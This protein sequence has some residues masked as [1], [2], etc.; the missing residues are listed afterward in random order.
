MKEIATEPP[1]GTKYE[2]YFA[3]LGK[4]QSDGWRCDLSYL[5]TRHTYFSLD[6]LNVELIVFLHED[7]CYRWNVNI[8]DFWGVRSYL[9]GQTNETEGLSAACLAAEDAGA[10]A[11]SR[12]VPDWVWPALENGWRPQAGSRSTS[13][14]G[15]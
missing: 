3:S 8:V 9:C 4:E 6:P 1:S 5:L 15:E 13:K 11:F 14:A 2:W 7:R 10:N 12:L